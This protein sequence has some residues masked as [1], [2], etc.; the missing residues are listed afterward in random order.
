MKFST[1]KQPIRSIAEDVDALLEELMED[2]DGNSHQLKVNTY[3][4]KNNR[5]ETLLVLVFVPCKHVRP[6][7]VNYFY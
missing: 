6:I 5:R 2:D 3:C 4:H 1:T 7:N